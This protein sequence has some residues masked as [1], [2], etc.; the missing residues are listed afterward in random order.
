[1]WL[2]TAGTNKLFCEWKPGQTKA[3]ILQSNDRPEC[4]TLRLHRIKVGIILNNHSILTRDVT[5]LP[6]E[7]TII[8]LDVPKEAVAV[9]LN[10][11]DYSFAK[12]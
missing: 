2:E 3:T 12:A 5:V 9:L 1:M 11:D 8:T 6:Q 4:K 10:Y 7:K